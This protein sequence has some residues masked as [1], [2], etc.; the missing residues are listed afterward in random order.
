LVKLHKEISEG[1]ERSDVEWVKAW[2][3]HGIV[4][5]EGH[6]ETAMDKRMRAQRIRKHWIG[7]VKLVC[8]IYIR[9]NR[10][11]NFRYTGFKSLSHFFDAIRQI[12]SS[13]QSNFEQ[14]KIE[15]E[16]FKS[17]IQITVEGLLQIA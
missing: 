12:Q 8:Q 5:R 7:C 11:G 2:Q 15:G 10:A 13:A 16:K 14:E 1:L 3:R 4:P 17:L 9:Q 6:N